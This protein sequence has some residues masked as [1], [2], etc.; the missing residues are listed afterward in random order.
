MHTSLLAILGRSVVGCYVR[1]ASSY[2]D[3][4]YVSLN[5]TSYILTQ[6]LNLFINIVLQYLSKILL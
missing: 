6:F 4:I 2:E 5:C 3:I 1:C